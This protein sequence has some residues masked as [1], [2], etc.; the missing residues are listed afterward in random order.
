[1]IT[2]VVSC[3]L[4]SIATVRLTSLVDDLCLAYVNWLGVLDGW[5]DDWDVVESVFWGDSCEGC[6]VS[7][8]L[9]V[10]SVCT[11][12]DVDLFDFTVENYTENTTIDKEEIGATNLD[13]NLE[14]NNYNETFH[15][16]LT[17][18]LHNWKVI[19]KLEGSLKEG[20][21]E[22]VSTSF[23]CI[24]RCDGIGMQFVDV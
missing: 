16:I 15:P 23:K 24:Q 22:I 4:L 7:F 5:I 11:P 13:I 21:S 14:S 2:V 20:V 6:A 3:V 8:G 10:L 1:M 9:S 18:N 17:N 12:I 19:V